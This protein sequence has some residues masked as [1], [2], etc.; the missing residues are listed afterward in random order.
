MKDEEI[1]LKMMYDKLNECFNTDNTVPKWEVEKG[2]DYVIMHTINS[3]DQENIYLEYDEDTEEWRFACNNIPYYVIASVDEIIEEINK[4]YPRP[5][6]TYEVY[7]NLNKE[8]RW[9]YH[10]E[11]DAYEQIEYLKNTSVFGGNFVIRK[12]TREVLI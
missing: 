3:T 1:M 10:N 2:I 12:V 8:V 11:E 4:E 9:T 5:E 6:V 7:D